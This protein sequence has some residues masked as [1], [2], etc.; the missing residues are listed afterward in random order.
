MSI[1]I[2]FDNCVKDQ[3]L[4][5]IFMISFGFGTLLTTACIL[6][7]KDLFRSI[8]ERLFFE[9]KT[10][11]Y[12]FVNVEQLNCENKENSLLNRP[13]KQIKFMKDVL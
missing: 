10:V 1:N 11:I 3:T 5:F 12:E 6:C 13:S 4:V 2:Y 8:V 7:F 9:F